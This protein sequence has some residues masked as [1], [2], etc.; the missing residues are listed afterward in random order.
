MA[1]IFPGQQW[2]HTEDLIAF[3]STFLAK[4]KPDSLVLIRSQSL[5]SSSVPSKSRR[6]ARSLAGGVLGLEESEAPTLRGS[7]FS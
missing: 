3:A 4:A 2:V 5:T 6:G 1:L 7:L